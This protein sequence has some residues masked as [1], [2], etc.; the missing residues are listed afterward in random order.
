MATK[1]GNVA[2]P[3]KNDKKAEKKADAE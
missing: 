3:A 2:Q 1:K